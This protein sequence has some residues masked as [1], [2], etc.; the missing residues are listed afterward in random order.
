MQKKLAFALSGGGSR[1]ALQVGAM[2]A[3]LEHGL[4]PDMLIGA[5]IGAANASFLALNG[6]SR[7]SL[8]RLADAWR[9]AHSTNLMPPNYIWLTV[10]AMVGR[11]S[12]D[13]SRHLRNF[14]IHH[15]V[16]PELSFADITGTQLVIVSA[17]LNTG[18]PILHGE[19]PEDKV[20]DALLLSTA[21]PP[22]FMP[23]RKQERYLVDGGVVSNLPIEPAIKLGAT[24]I[25]ALDLIDSREILAAGDGVRGFLDRLI[26][27]V[28]K[29]QL[30]LEMQLAQARGI[31]LLYLGLT[32]ETLVPI[33][34]F[35]HSDDLIARGYEITRRVIESEQITHPILALQG[36]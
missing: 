32:G 6:F 31:P 34:D 5:S 30:D 7:D 20:L 16:T 13:P 29:R 19:D 2:V 28:E 27:S 33:W 35:Q 23:V 9:F 25:V 11:S 12:S 10:R 18:K 17:D 1:G 26:F 24:E 22:W 8:A 14:L 3:L 36:E 21:L 4:Q 15:G